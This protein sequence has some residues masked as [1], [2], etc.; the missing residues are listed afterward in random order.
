MFLCPPL[1]F[2]QTPAI[3]I[4][5]GAANITWPL[6]A[7]YYLLQT[8]TNLSASN[9][10]DNVATASPLS[11][12]Y[13]SSIPPQTTVAT[14]A[15]V[16]TNV[17]GTNFVISQPFADN[18]RFY[19]LR[20]PQKPLEIPIFSFTIFY[21]GLL[22][23]SDSST[24]TINGAVHANGPIYLGTT[25]GLTQTFNNTITTANAISSPM[26][27]GI[28]YTAWTNSPSVKLNGRPPYVTN[29]PIFISFF[30]TT[31]PHAILEIPPPG[32][33]PDF[34]LGRARLFN[35]AQVV[36][37]V[38]NSPSGANPTVYL[39]LQ[40]SFQG[41]VPGND[42][43]KVNY[44][45]TNVTSLLL[46]TNLN[47]A[48]NIAMPFLSLTNTFVDQ[49]E[50]KTNLV[51]QIDVGAYGDWALT[52]PIVAGKLNASFYPTILYVADRR[53]G[54]SKNLAVVR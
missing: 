42:P 19:R 24:L 45:L 34:I 10:W 35:Q 41:A 15:A 2:A 20:A 40:R 53:T 5:N 37:I 25:P 54:G 46:L 31:N 33:N 8:T 49:R 26:N 38:T 50:N 14:T 39:T 17:L 22:E 23:F 27:G 21:S 12:I 48:V 43:A 28:N 16:I 1:S 13:S 44:Q 29:T 7:Y 47:N 18:Q 36:L 30:G 32:E 11:S 3:N 52:N 9:A 4:S 6:T 51:T